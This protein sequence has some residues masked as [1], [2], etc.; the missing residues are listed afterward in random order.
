VLVWEA[1]ASLSRH[2]DKKLRSLEVALRSY[3]VM[4]LLV[5]VVLPESERNG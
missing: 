3:N 4:L 2:S 5:L 1:G